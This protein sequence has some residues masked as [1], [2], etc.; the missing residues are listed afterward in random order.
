MNRRTVLIAALFAALAVGYGFGSGAGD[1]GA[2]SSR[3]LVGLGSPAAAVI[4]AD[5]HPHSIS[6]GPDSQTWYYVEKDGAVRPRYE[7]NQ[8][9]VVRIRHTK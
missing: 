9:L 4:A 3:L 2:T 1:A 7:V 8:G 6:Y 5:G